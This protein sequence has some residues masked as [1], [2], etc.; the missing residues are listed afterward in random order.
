MFL[1]DES[2]Q[3][4]LPNGVPPTRDRLDGVRGQR[5]D[6][7]DAGGPSRVD[8]REFIHAIRA[9]PSTMTRG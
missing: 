7:P 3:T 8:A 1:F 6:R 4:L 5:G 9:S 2:P